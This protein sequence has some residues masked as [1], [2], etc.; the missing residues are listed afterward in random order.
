MHGHASMIAAAR[1]ATPASAPK[2][3]SGWTMVTGTQAL[4]KCAA[5]VGIVSIVGENSPLASRQGCCPGSRQ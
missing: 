1:A 3:G 2:L 5:L 4:E